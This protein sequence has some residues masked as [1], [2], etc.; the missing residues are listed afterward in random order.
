M[1]RKQIA[2]AA[3]ATVIA[4]AAAPWALAQSHR[5]APAAYEPKLDPKQFTTRIDNPYFPLPVGRRLVYKGAKDGKTQKDVVTVTARTKLVAEGIRAR[6]V[7]D[8]ATHNG[9]LL[10]K[11]QDWYAQDSAGNVWYVGEKTA[12][13]EN[14]TVDRSGSW[15]AGVHDAEPGII[16]KAHPA[17]PD[18]YR[19]EYLRGE[20]EDT[21]WTVHLGGTVRTP[22]RTFHGTLTSLEATR[23]EP[24]LYDK[25]VYARGY[26]IVVERAVTGAPEWDKLVK[27]TG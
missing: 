17:I 19:Q 21:A 8:I 22:F 3:G 2:V 26:G 27:V 10:E 23:I 11:T 5:S 16:M 18:A 6:I 25:K 12:S 9:K 24:G 20:A 15:E 1:M 7:T 4:A 14:G 13:Y